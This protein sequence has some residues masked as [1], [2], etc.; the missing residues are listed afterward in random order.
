MKATWFSLL[1]FWV[2]VIPYLL[3]KEGNRSNITGKGNDEST[4]ALPLPGVCH[5]PPLDSV[6]SLISAKRVVADVTQAEAWNELAWPSLF[7]P[8]SRQ[9]HEHMPWK[10]FCIIYQFIRFVFGILTSTNNFL[11]RTFFS[12][13]LYFGILYFHFIWKYRWITRDFYFDPLVNLGMCDLIFMYFVFSKI[14]FVVV[15]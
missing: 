12:Y 8:A 9:S 11:L 1:L 3:Q 4:T 5:A 7:I 10:L 13:I 6:T 14:P 2:F 15:F